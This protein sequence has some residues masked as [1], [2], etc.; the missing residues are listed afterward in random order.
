MNTRDFGSVS[1][2]ILIEKLMYNDL[3][4]QMVR[5]IENW[6]SDQAQRMAIGTK[7]S[8]RQVTSGVS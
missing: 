2:K 3:D 6:L 7:S 1:L 4:Q 8:W 5:W